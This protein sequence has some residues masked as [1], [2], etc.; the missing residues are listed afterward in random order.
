M[1][2]NC[3]FG[4][5]C[6]PTGCDQASWCVFRYKVVI[7]TDPVVF[8]MAKKLLPRSHA[9]RSFR[10]VSKDENLRFCDAELLSNSLHSR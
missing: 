6:R 3:Q 2:K 1:R 10:C 8:A 5:P 9:A 7:K 4:K